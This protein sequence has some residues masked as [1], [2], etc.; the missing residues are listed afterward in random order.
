MRDRHEIAG[1]VILH[2]QTTKPENVLIWQYTSNNTPYPKK[3]PERE[4]A[5]NRQGG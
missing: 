3:K 2:S 4:A 5:L 1:C